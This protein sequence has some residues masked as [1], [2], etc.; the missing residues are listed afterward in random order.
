MPGEKSRNAE[1]M[2]KMNETVEK[3]RAALKA[4]Q[5]QLDGMGGQLV[6]TSISI[7]HIHI[8]TECRHWTSLRFYPFRLSYGLPKAATRYAHFNFHLYIS[9]N[10]ARFTHN[11]INQSR[12]AVDGTFSRAA[13]TLRRLAGVDES[14][15]ICGRAI[16]R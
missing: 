16:S 9:C 2:N 5:A 15:K 7:Y 4:L 14:S 1:E 13:R 6:G 3:L 8:Y 12:H 11:M 10:E